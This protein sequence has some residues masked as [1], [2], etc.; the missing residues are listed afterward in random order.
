MGP[1]DWIKSDIGQWEVEEKGGRL[2]LATE[3]R[4]EL[5]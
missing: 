5:A 1:D 3:Q 2:V 4:E